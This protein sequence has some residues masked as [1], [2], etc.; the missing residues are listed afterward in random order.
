M[1]RSQRSLVLGGLIGA[2]VVLAGIGALAQPNKDQAIDPSKEWPT[3]GHD[4]GGM[5]FSPLTEITPAN[6]ARLKVAWVY[7]MAVPGAVAASGGFAA[8]RGGAGREGI[9]PEG[10]TPDAPP[11]GRGRG[12][13]NPNG[14]AASEVRMADVRRRSESHCYPVQSWYRWSRQQ[15]AWSRPFLL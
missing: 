9:A 12:R 10:E 5:R 4:P 2:T 15:T 14:F 3:Y 11:A 7:H 6:V 1:K 13:G 8:A